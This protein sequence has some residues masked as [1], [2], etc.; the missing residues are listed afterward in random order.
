MKGKSEVKFASSVEKKLDSM[1]E[2][3]PKTN[4]ERRTKSQA[5]SYGEKR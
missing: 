3:L 2:A 5:A 4:E 1:A